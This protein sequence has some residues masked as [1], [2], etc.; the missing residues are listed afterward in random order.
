MAN[1]WFLV[2]IVGD[3]AYRNPY[4]PRYTDTS[5]IS[6][7]SGQR[8]TVNGSEYYAARFVGTQSALDEVEAYDDATSLQ[9]SGYTE[10]DVANWLNDKTSH[11]YTFPEWEDR[12]LT[13]DVSV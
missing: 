2:T 1:R 7:W 5:G 8:V 3:G 4:Q 10:S 11:N 6:G 12:F 9:E 13:G